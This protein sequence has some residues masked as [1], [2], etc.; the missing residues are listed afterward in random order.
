SIPPNSLKALDD[1]FDYL[2]LN[3]TLVVEIGGHTNGLPK[4]DFCDSLSLLRAKAVAEYLTVKGIPKER[5]TYVGYGRRK[6][7]DTNATREGRAKNQ[8]VELKILSS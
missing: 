1:I 2:M 5:M 6:P 7:V 8:R 3:Q 4:D